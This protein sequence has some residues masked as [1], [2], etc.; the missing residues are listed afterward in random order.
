MS[1]VPFSMPQL[2]TLALWTSLRSESLATF[3][4]PLLTSTLL[5]MIWQKRRGEK[6]GPVDVPLRQRSLSKC[7]D[8]IVFG[9]LCTSAPD[10]RS[11]A[12]ALSSAIP[13]AGDWLNVVPCH[14]LGLHLHDWEFR[15]CLQYWLGLRMTE[16]ETRCPICQA[17]ADPFGYH[18]VGCRGN[19]YLPNWLRGQPAALDVTVISTMQ[20][21]T[22]A[23][24]SSTQGHALTVGEEKKDGRACGGL[25][26]RGRDLHP[27]GGWTDG[28]VATIKSIGRLLGQRLGTPPAPPIPTSRHLSV[29]RQ[30]LHVDPPHAG[31]IS[32][33]GRSYLTCTVF[34]LFCFF[35]FLSP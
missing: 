14:A 16:E 1:A 2:P 25:P 18:Q 4:V 7:I 20:Q 23:R 12:L 10:T 24:A 17:A 28:S 8:Q 33:C 31:R 13:H 34:L 5:P 15:L 19:V 22:V 11:K 29:E 32:C 3:L 30:C 35:V 27:F 9:E 26:I 6:T 21:L